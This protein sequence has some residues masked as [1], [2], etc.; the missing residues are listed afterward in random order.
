MSVEGIRGKY[1]KI[2][3]RILELKNSKCSKKWSKEESADDISFRTNQ[4][5]DA[6]MITSD[7]IFEPLNFFSAHMQMCGIY[8]YPIEINNTFP[9]NNDQPRS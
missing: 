4:E 2:R 9:Y 3:F 1:F 7:L 6:T 5:R 8:K